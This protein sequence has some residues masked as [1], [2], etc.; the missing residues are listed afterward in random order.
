MVKDFQLIS[1][2]HNFAKLV[3]KLLAN[4]LPG[5]LNEMVAANQSA[6]VKGRCIQDNFVLVQQIA[7]YLHQQKQP[8]ILLKLD[9][10]KAFDSVSSPFL[11]EVFQRKGFG[12]NFRNMIS[13]IHSL[14]PSPPQW[15]SRRHPLPLS[16]S[17]TR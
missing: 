14:N 7:K 16:L 6:F 1:L 4:R 12:L 11:L 9:I 10:S 2:I 13:R 17:K 15:D 8:H 5:K 3:A